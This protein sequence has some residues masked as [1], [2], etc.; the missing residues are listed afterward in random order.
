MASTK[1]VPTGF[2]FSVLTVIIYFFS[3]VRSKNEHILSN[4]KFD[5]IYQLGDSIADT[6][7]FVQD[8]PSSV[9]AGLPY[10]ETLKKPT[11]RCSDGLLM[12]DYIALSAGLPF[13]DAY[14]NKDGVFY[15]GVNFA[16]AGATAM[17]VEDLY[18]KNIS[19]V[20]TS[21]SLSAQLDWMSNYFKTTCHYAKDCFNKNGRALFMVG[22][23]GGNDYNYPCFQGKNLAEAKTM[24]PEVVRS[25]KHAAKRVI[26]YGAKRLVVPGNFPIGC[27]P[28][29]LSLF[30]TNDA[31]A[32]DELHCLKELNQFSVYHN[33]LLQKAIDELKEEHHDVIIVYGD[34]Y[35][36][37]V[38]LFTKAN[39]LGFDPTSLQKACC[40][41]GGDYNFDL[42]SLCGDPEVTVCENPDERLSWDGI[43]LTQ[44]AYELMATWLIHDIYPK[45]Q[46]EYVA[47]YSSAA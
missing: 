13:L 3:F 4:C 23:I 32:Y 7:N 34:Y 24:G 35:N 41:L 42:S 16:V 19:F 30:Q 8:N 21:M 25:I 28:V 10:G 2:A 26:G 27:F 38:W 14:L 17:S 9:F 15:H 44:R 18:K 22:E 43:H 6:G 47:S 5:A 29:Y 33:D 40:G 20:P 39:M 46:C 37:F 11:G 31:S 36:A 1:C 12:I 45:L